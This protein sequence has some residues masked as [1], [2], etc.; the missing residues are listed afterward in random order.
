MVLDR[1]T[2]DRRLAELEEVLAQLRSME[3]EVGNVAALEEDLSRRWSLERGLLASANLV[4]DVANHISVGHFAVHPANYE[5][6]LRLLSA[7]GVIREETYEKLRGLGGFRNV[8]AHEY[9]DI[10]LHEVVRWRTRILAGLPQF[11]GQVIRWL[12]D[13]PAETGR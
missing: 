13:L 3:D 10:D 12:T 8:L 6:G 5:D 1:R 4:F 11:M 9:L 7:H 2:V